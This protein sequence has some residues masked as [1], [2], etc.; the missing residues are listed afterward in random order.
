MHLSILRQ[1]IQQRK[2][3][4]H[5]NDKSFFLYQTSLG[6]FR[7][8]MCCMQHLVPVLILPLFIDQC[9]FVTCC[10][11]LITSAKG[12]GDSR[13]LFVCL[14]AGKITWKVIHRFYGQIFTNFFIYEAVCL[15]MQ[16]WQKDVSLRIRLLR[17]GK[18]KRQR[19]STTD[20]SDK[21]EQSTLR[22]ILPVRGIDHWDSLG[23][24]VIRENRKK[25][26][27]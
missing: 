15:K 23:R 8:C 14:L 25:N 26:T 7:S 18:K 4:Q 19:H 1:G 27:F 12:G 22:P 16:R 6:L 13:R 11:L 10:Q 17:L 3:W 24:T 9:S 21:P 5:D 20:T 2:R